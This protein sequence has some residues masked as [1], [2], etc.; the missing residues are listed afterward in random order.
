MS[1]G[2]HGVEG[3]FGSAVQ[4]AWLSRQA[5]GERP[6][7]DGAVV[8]IHAVNPY[9]FA[10]LRRTNEDN[11]DLNR[12]YLDTDD[13]YA[14]APDG[15]EALN[16]F[17]NPASPPSSLDPFRLKALWHIRRLGLPTLKTAVAGGSTGFHKGC[18]SVDT[19]P[20]P[21]PGSYGSIWAAG[22]AACRGRCTSISTAGWARSGNT[23]CS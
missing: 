9:G 22:L 11:V 4:L 12:N 2:V 13:A 10:K 3:F 5:A 14:G 15:Y 18:S 17:L 1:S 21:Q 8:L 6:P 19:V 7:N 23:G 16:R 20:Q